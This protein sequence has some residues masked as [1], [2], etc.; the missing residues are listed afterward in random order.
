MIRLEPSGTERL[1][2]SGDDYL[3]LLAPMTARAS[4]Q[5]IQDVTAK[6]DTEVPETSTRVMILYRLSNGFAQPASRGESSFGALDGR[7]DVQ[8]RQSLPFMNFSSVPA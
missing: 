1:L 4:T 6:I 2:Q 3:M 5:T 7:F 8:V